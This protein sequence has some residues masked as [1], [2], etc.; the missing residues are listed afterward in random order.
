MG[1]KMY[2]KIFSILTR[3]KGTK[4]QVSKVYEEDTSVQNIHKALVPDTKGIFKDYA[5]EQ[6]IQCVRSAYTAPVLR[7]FDPINRYEY[8]LSFPVVFS[9]SLNSLEDNITVSYR[10]QD[11]YAIDIEQTTVMQIN[12]DNNTITF[13]RG[14]REGET[15]TYEYTDGLTEAI[16][17]SKWVTIHLK[18]VPAG[19]HTVELSYKLPYTRTLLDVVN[20]LPISASSRYE[21]IKHHQL[22]DFIA[23]IVMDVCYKQERL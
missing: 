21:S 20:D 18:D 6:L 22:P 8:P 3:G 17:L 16:E 4:R 7:L 14:D 11:E 1:L 9:S 15:I 10:E 19:V 12:E 23:S 13:L 5:A 2:N